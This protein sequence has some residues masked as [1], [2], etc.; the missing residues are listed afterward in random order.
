MLKQWNAM[1]FRSVL[2]NGRTKPLVI[3]CA[4]IPDSILVDLDA[5][6]QVRR[7]FVV[8]AIGN[9]EVDE[10]LIIKELLGN[11]FA[12]S[13]GLTT[14]EPGLIRISDV[15]AKTVNPTLSRKYGF[16]ISPGI[17]AGCE[18][19]RGGLTPPPTNLFFTKAELAPLA[20]LYGFDLVTQ[21]P[22]RLP[23]RP[24]FGLMG[25]NVV[26]FDFDQ[27]F[28]FLYP[29]FLFLGEPWEVSKHGIAQKHFCYPHF[30]NARDPIVWADNIN[31]MMSFSDELLGA[32]TAWVPETWSGNSA[33]VR[34]HLAE[35]REHLGAFELELQGSVQ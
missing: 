18:F 29:L 20:V 7:E 5:A 16:Q 1:G 10:S 3:E 32:L 33:K 11:L 23:N 35:I 34:N 27:C 21:N 9:P 31:A 12:R 25:R 6:A 8:K 24:N 14:P 4:Q 22:D 15:F 13:Y 19:I 17:A 2:D 26:A 28:S 30:K